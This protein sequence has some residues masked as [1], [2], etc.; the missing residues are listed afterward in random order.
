M[1]HRKHIRGDGPAMELPQVCPRAVGCLTYDPGAHKSRPNV[2]GLIHF[3]DSVAE[4]VVLL[5]LTAARFYYIGSACMEET[6]PSVFP[7]PQ[8]NVVTLRKKD[9]KKVIF[10]KHAFS[11]F[12]DGNLNFVPL[13][14][15]LHSYH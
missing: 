6:R 13:V 12:S 11:F 10:K 14:L 9:V 8:A 7:P 4:T 15:A 3:L 2:Y 5:F 1:K